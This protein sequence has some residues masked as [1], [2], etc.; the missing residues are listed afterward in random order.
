MPFRLD[1]SLSIDKTE[2]INR[3][4]MKLNERVF[5]SPHLQPIFKTEVK[6]ELENAEYLHENGI[7]LPLHDIWGT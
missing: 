4:K 1:F 5:L 2:T 6:I 7:C 3:L